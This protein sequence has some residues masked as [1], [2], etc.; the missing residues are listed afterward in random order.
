MKLLRSALVLAAL[1]P[2]LCAAADAPPPD[3]ARQLE[4][5]Y[6]GDEIVESATRA[7]TPLSQVAENVTV[8][9]AEEIEAMGAH[10]LAEV[11]NRV[12]GVFVE[13]FSGVHPGTLTLPHIQGS[14]ES[15]GWQRWYE[16]R[17]VTLLVDGMPWNSMGSS[18]FTDVVPLT[19]VDRVEILKGPAS[20]IWGS[21]LGGVINVITKDVG[22]ALRPQGGARASYGQRGAH[23]AGVELWGGAGPVGYYLAGESQQA[24]WDEAGADSRSRSVFAKVRAVLGP[25]VSLAAS[26]GWSR[27]E[28]DLGH[29]VSKASLSQLEHRALWGQAS[30]DA[31]L[32]EG[33]SLYAAAHWFGLR[34]DDESQEDGL[35][36]PRGDLLADSQWKTRDRGLQGRLTWKGESHTAVAGVD[37][38]S[39]RLTQ[40]TDNGEYFQSLGQAA[41]VGTAVGSDRVGA[42]V[43]DTVR[44]GPL[45]VAPGLRYDNAAKG[46]D[47]W[48]PSLGVTCPLG[49][50][51]LLRA[52]AARGFTYPPVWYVAGSAGELV[53]NPDLRPE[54]V[55]SYQV[56]IEGTLPGLWLKVTGFRHD[57]TDTIEVVPVPGTALTTFANRGH[58]WRKGFEAEAETAAWNGLSAKG[59]FALLQIDRSGA[60]RTQDQ[61]QANL[62]LSHRLGTWRA[63]LLGHFVWWDYAG[64]SREGRV[65]DFL[66]DLAASK[67]LP[68]VAGVEPEVYANVRNLF[69]G[70][71]SVELDWGTEHRWAEAGLRVR[72]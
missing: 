6:F 16:E 36:A 57:V 71:Q 24:D 49:Q 31:R 70:K 56:G 38:L 37:Y 63:Q 39:Q 45:A 13:P 28:W 17:H 7:P 14:G 2:S 64:G 61:Y 72:F 34:L 4:A 62:G 48:S 25:A 23:D 53:A 43:N 29:R 66:W 22:K 35:Y 58:A 5:L 27:P 20:S 55:W 67:G 46:G 68:A 42:Y 26:G 47:F 10:T 30:L 33:L 54:K 32:S 69:N 9:T 21:A 19:I 3:E 1:L 41:H 51:F 52:Q 65:N 59:G 44:L 18:A 11:L 60:E 12:T 8:V 50:G 40:E 15:N